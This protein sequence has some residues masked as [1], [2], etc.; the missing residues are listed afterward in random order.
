VFAN[1]IRQALALS[2]EA[3]TETEKRSANEEDDAAEYQNRTGPSTKPIRYGRPNAV[4]EIVSDMSIRRA[5]PHGT[6]YP[7][8]E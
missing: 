1:V 7:N 5:S 8:N 3:V 4:I 6:V 2:P